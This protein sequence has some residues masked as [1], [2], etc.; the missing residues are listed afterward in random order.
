M[1]KIETNEIIKRIKERRIRLNLSYQDLADKT[2][3]SKSTLQRYETGFIKNLPI[4]KLEI[5]AFALN[6]SPSY[7]MG[8]EKESG[9]SSLEFKTIKNPEDAI[10][11]ILK[12]PTLM[13]YGGYDINKMTNDEIVDFANELLRQLELLS[14]K[15]KYKK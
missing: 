12:Q 1:K 14:Y 11:F 13:A 10:T 5:L 9:T 3:I 4:D 2:G 7:L 15:Y 8:W 6:A